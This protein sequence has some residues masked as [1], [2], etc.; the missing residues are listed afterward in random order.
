MTPRGE[1]SAAPDL[2]PDAARGPTGHIPTDVPVFDVR[3]L[4]VA[5]GGQ[6]VLGP[7]DLRIERGSF[8]G[9]LGPNGSGKTTL[10]RALAGG[11]KPSAGEVLLEGHPVRQ[12][13]AA[14]LARIVGVVPQQFNLDFSFTV[15]EMVAMGRYAHRGRDAA[16]AGGPGA[17]PAG[18]R[19]AATDVGA[20][21]AVGGP[22]AMPTGGG[23]SAAPGGGG[24]QVA[25]D[26]AAV[27]TALEATGMTALARRLVTELSGGER[28]RALIAQTLAQETPV[29]LLDEP[30]NNLD[31]N[32]QLEIMQLLGSLHATGRTIAVVLHDLNIAAQYCEELVL[33]DK[34]R[35]AARGE[36]ADILDPNLILE[37]F[38]V[39]VAVHRQGQRPYLTPLWS[40]SHEGA[41]EGGGTK[42]HVIA[43]GGAAS[44]LME[45]LVLRGY[46]PTVGIVSVFDTD[47]ATAQRYEL[48]VVSA[49]PFQPF[50]AEAVAEME[51]LVAETDVLVV[52]PVFF[53]PGNLEPLRVALRA[54][55]AGRKVLMA[56]RPPIEERDL[57]NGEATELVGRLFAAGAVPFSDVRQALALVA[58]VTGA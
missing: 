39:R 16:K 30:L 8:L 17:A 36:A 26:S 20:E 49:P 52:S 4:E 51:S 1:P 38:R 12:Y 5:L 53:G 18:G 24:A 37:V 45:E 3:G 55:Q 19:G 48:E 28:Q 15:E 10:L 11:V 50:P 41:R 31:L 35:V 54:L 46:A 21:A 2:R 44:E 29:L 58:G 14:Q 57:S 9:I 56:D 40:R 42:V 7:L 22:A 34:G 25:A 43:G 23:A 47:Y 27:A 33:L 13:H 32:H 6:P